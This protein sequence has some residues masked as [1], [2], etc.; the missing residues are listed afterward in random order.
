[1]AKKE[2]LYMKRIEDTEDKKII[3]GTVAGSAVFQVRFF[4][5]KQVVKPAVYEGVVLPSIYE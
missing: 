1:M 4:S 5:D 2:G 3:L